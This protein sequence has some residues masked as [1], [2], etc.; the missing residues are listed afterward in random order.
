MSVFRISENKYIG[1]YSKMPVRSTPDCIERSRQYHEICGRVRALLPTAPSEGLNGF[2]NAIGN[3]ISALRT[4]D[5]KQAYEQLK[6]LRDALGLCVQGRRAHYGRCVDDQGTVEDVKHSWAIQAMQNAWDD[7]GKAVRMLEAKH[8]DQQRLQSTKTYAQCV[9]DLD[10]RRQQSEAINSTCL[11]TA[12]DRCTANKK[13]IKQKQKKAK[14]R[15]EENYEDLISE[16]TALDVNLSTTLSETKADNMTFGELQDLLF[17]FDPTIDSSLRLLMDKSTVT[18][19]TFPYLRCR[20]HTLSRF[21]KASQ[22]NMVMIVVIL[23]HCSETSR[24][25]GRSNKLS[26]LKAQALCENILVVWTTIFES[27]SSDT[28][29]MLSCNNPAHFILSIIYCMQSVGFYLV[30]AGADGNV[31]NLW[32]N[33]FNICGAFF[34]LN[35]MFGQILTTGAVRLTGFILAHFRADHLLSPGEAVTRA[36]DLHAEYSMTDGPHASV[37]NFER[38]RDVGDYKLMISMNTIAPGEL[39]LR[40]GIPERG[41]PLCKVVMIRNMEGDTHVVPCLVYPSIDESEKLEL[42]FTDMAEVL[43]EAIVAVYIHGITHGVYDVSETYT[44][45]FLPL[46]HFQVFIDE[47]AV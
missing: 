25:T 5:T 4:R 6:H 26:A 34:R 35:I 14:Q 10:R 21:L 18:W 38:A 39:S 42:H 30:A 43:L 45:T 29:L 22:L 17:K 28:F 15:Q 20:L 24:E 19:S 13:Q 1:F 7:C 40:D 3:E 23:H 31:Y 44:R 47:L 16:F 2:L 46:H 36:R 27:L 37:L 32:I 11:S 33:A 12:H 9:E 8:S 41:R